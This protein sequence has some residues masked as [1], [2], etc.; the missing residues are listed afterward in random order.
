MSKKLLE[1]ACFS[2]ESAVI[3]QSAGADRIELCEDYSSG[4]HSPSLE[5][6]KKTRKLIKIPLHVMIRPRPTDFSELFP[7]SDPHEFNYSE[8]EI[9]WMI[10]YT[11]ACQLEGI[12][13]I[14]FGALTKQKEIDTQ[15]CSRLIEVAQN[16]SLT[17]HR[18]IDDCA[19]IKTGIENIISLGF[20]RVLTS[21]AKPNAMEGLQTLTQLQ[22]DFGDKITIMPGGGIR[23]GNIKNLLDTGCR[24]F[25]SAALKGNEITPDPSEIE[26]IK[27]LL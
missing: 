1:I 17:F 15:V 13:G 20:H 12:D 18:A 11:I 19:N 5:E 24:E 8:M 10:G 26:K 14:V 2:L 4:G 9:Q 23:S 25:H 16:M 27:S 22:K 21:G 3:A 6:I 7:L